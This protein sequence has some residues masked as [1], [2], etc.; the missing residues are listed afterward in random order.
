MKV[1]GREGGGRSKAL[2]FW[3]YLQNI[4]QG[5]WS[6]A[7]SNQLLRSPVTFQRPP[8]LYSTSQ[9]ME[10]MLIYTYILKDTKLQSAY[11]KQINCLCNILKTKCS[12]SRTIRRAKKWKTLATNLLQSPI[13]YQ[14]N[15]MYWGSSQKAIKADCTRVFPLCY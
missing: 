2:P 4:S 15:I 1:L 11:P 13:N 5:R 3:Q 9:D 14:Q 10:K 6:P 12:T 8:A 7:G